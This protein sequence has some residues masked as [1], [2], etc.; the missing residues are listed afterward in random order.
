M[1]DCDLFY[2][3]IS[4]SDNNIKFILTNRDGYIIESYINYNLIFRI[5]VKREIKEYVLGTEGCFVAT[6][7][8]YVIRDDNG[9]ILVDSTREFGAGKITLFTSEHANGVC[10]DQLGELGDVITACGGQD[11]VFKYFIAIGPDKE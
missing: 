8:D 2:E 3:I 9:K 10:A 4:D 7:Q 5:R 6:K 1:K 11:N